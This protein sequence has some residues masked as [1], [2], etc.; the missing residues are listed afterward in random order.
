MNKRC[1]QIGSSSNTL[2]VLNSDKLIESSTHAYFANMSLCDPELEL[3]VVDIISRH[4]AAGDKEYLILQRLKLVCRCFYEKVNVFMLSFIKGQH[5]EDNF[6]SGRIEMLYHEDVG[7]LPICM[8]SD[9]TKLFK[10][11]CCSL[12]NFDKLECQVFVEIYKDHVDSLLGFWESNNFKF[13][14]SSF[15]TDYSESTST[16]RGW[17][18]NFSIVFSDDR[19]VVV[20]KYISIRFLERYFSSPKFVCF[21]ASDTDEDLKN[22]DKILWFLRTNLHLRRVSSLVSKLIDILLSPSLFSITEEYSKRLAFLAEE[23]LI[24][25]KQ[26]ANF[27]L[28]KIIPLLNI[29]DCEISVMKILDYF[30]Q[31]EL[32]EVEVVAKFIEHLHELA[33]DCQRPKVQ[34]SAIRL[35]GFLISKKLADNVDVIVNSIVRCFTLFLEEDVKY[36]IVHFLAL[37]IDDFLDFET[38]NKLVVKISP[39]LK[40]HLNCPLIEADICSFITS[41]AKKRLGTTHIT[42]ELLEDVSYAFYNDCGRLYEFFTILIE[43]GFSF[44]DSFAADLKVDLAELFCTWSDCTKDAAKLLP[45]MT[46]KKERY[47]LIYEMIIFYYNEELQ[48]AKSDNLSKEDKEQYSYLKK[49]NSTDRFERILIIISKFSQELELDLE[50]LKADV[51]ILIKEVE[52]TRKD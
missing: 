22:Y 32:L 28:P 19:E 9:Q 2:K 8:Y 14:F 4:L 40:K 5:R 10:L 46:T 31:S 16:L 1:D 21:L 13:L 29:Q 50:K 51:E 27:M 52:A 49:R 7:S 30:A 39:L 35:C 15:L 44:D 23:E 45:L 25:S 18:H 20:N 12:R 34:S 26:I 24:G 11:F 37:V 36:A 17:G 47:Q 43:H 33:V 41:F 3:V 48:L 6:R 42:E 38:S